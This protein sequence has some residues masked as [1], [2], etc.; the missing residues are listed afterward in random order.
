VDREWK[1]G[2]KRSKENLSFQRPHIVLRR[3]MAHL[4]PPRVLTKIA[5]EERALENW[6]R[7]AQGETTL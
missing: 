7:L 5:E 1:I 2:G 6:T 3:A 4:M